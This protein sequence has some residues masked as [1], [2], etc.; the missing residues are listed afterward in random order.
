MH[1]QANGVP[2]GNVTT[3]CGSVRGKVKRGLQVFK[4]IR[5]KVCGGAASKIE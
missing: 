5:G 3:Q 4:D 2:F 1:G